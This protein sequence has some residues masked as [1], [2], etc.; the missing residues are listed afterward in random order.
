MTQLTFDESNDLNP[1]WSPDGTKLLFQSDRD[2]F[3]QIYELDLATGELTWLSDGMGDD[4]DPQYSNDGTRITYRTYRYGENS[5]IVVANA[6]GSDAQVVSDP[7][8][9]ALN[10]AF[11][12][13]DTLMAYQSNLDGDDDIYVYEFATGL[14]RLVT[15]NAVGDYA[16]TWWCYAPV[17]LFTSDVKEDSNIFQTPALPIDGDAIDVETDASQLTF[18]EES[19]QYPQN[20]PSEENASR[21]RK[22]PGSSKNK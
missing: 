18:T 9:D 20:T 8:G 3:W 6:D 14:T 10:Q 16:P 19:D 12:P 7:E 13:D 22:V 2:G 5:V 17:L 15:D 4:H 21:E 1:F 11:S